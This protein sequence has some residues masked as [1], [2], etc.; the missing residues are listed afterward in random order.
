M[1]CIFVSIATSARQISHSF[2]NFGSYLAARG[3]TTR[4]RVLH[5]ASAFI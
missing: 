3:D 2:I 1:I 5:N 4:K